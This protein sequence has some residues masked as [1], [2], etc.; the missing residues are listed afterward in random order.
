MK[1]ETKRNVRNQLL[2]K[3]AE[4]I[5]RKMAMDISNIENV[6]SWAE[7]T[8]VSRTWLYHAMNRTYGKNPKQ[9]I[10][11]KRYEKII[12]VIEG[13][14]DACGYHV[15]NSAGLPDEKALYK[16]LAN[17]FDTTFTALRLDVLNSGNPD[18]HKMNKPDK[19]LTNRIR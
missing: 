8:G 13:D 16:F 18:H 15:A 2:T 7:T 5:F 6:G 1:R 3:K 19:S 4:G 11:D 12:E 14:P 10:R 17:H 9:L